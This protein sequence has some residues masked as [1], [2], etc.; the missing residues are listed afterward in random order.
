MTVHFRDKFALY[1][2]VRLALLKVFIVILVFFVFPFVFLLPFATVKVLG[3][4]LLTEHVY[5]MSEEYFDYVNDFGEDGE[6]EKAAEKKELTA[7]DEMKWKRLL[8]NM[9]GA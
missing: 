8:G 7:L 4:F 3:L 2:P 5:Q 6:G 1:E 9:S